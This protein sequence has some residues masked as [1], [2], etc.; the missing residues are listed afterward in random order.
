MNRQ[1]RL[2]NAGA[3]APSDRGIDLAA[4][5]MTTQKMTFVAVAGLAVS[6]VWCVAQTTN[7]YPIPPQ[8]KLESFDTN[9]D[10]VVVKG[11]GL[12]GT[13]S[14]NGGSLSIMCEQITDAGTGR[15]QDGLA[16]GITGGGVADDVL[17]IDYDEIGSL[18]NA[19]DYL[20]KVDWSVTPLPSFD[21]AYTSKGG[22]RMSAFSS[23]RNGAIEFAV[24]TTRSSRPPVLLARDQVTQLRTF[25]SQ[26]KT[27]L[28]AIRK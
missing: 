12:I 7:I 11:A 3:D 8:T 4:R 25:V 6:A 2:L 27:K 21:A 14:A 22:L 26:A 9:T 10:T 19:I 20:N 1:D 5:S 17:L 24:R 18:L 16:I 15:I 13:V 28:D 23:Q